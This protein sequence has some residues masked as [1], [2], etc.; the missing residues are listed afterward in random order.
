MGRNDID[1][2]TVTSNFIIKTTKHPFTFNPILVLPIEQNT[3]TA[4]CTKS[5]YIQNSEQASGSQQNQQLT[6]EFNSSSKFK[7]LPKIIIRM[8]NH[9]FS[10][11]FEDTFSALGIITVF[12]PQTSVDATVFQQFVKAWKSEIKNN[13]R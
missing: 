1:Q 4:I 12:L 13:V 6:F 10:E 9:L 3:T 11:N 7:H 8:S 2:L 5:V